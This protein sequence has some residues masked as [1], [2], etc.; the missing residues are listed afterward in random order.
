MADLFKNQNN[1]LKG[2]NES[3]TFHQVFFSDI[4]KPHFTSP[5]L[6]RR[7][8]ENESNQEKNIDNFEKKHEIEEKTF[9]KQLKSNNELLFK[10]T[11]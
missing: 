5:K 3:D 11:K 9:I 10:V 1:N 4:P 7:P 2:F 6:N 8:K